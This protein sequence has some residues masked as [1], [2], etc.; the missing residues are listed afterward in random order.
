MIF[1]ALDFLVYVKPNYIISN[2]VLLIFFLTDREISKLGDLVNMDVCME[3]LDILYETED[4]SWLLNFAYPLA[5][6]TLVC[7][8]NAAC[9]LTSKR[10]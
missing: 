10:Y 8:L 2:R 7:P 4:T 3:I 1:I 5:A 6:S 9:P